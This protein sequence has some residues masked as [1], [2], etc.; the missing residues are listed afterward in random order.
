[1]NFH[2]SLKNVME[3]PI[4]IVHAPSCFPKMDKSLYPRRPLKPVRTK[5]Y[6]RNSDTPSTKPAK[7]MEVVI[8]RT[9]PIALKRE[10]M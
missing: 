8:Q 2:M 1:M 7:I 10:L 9:C 4:K 5:F 6:R 3:Q